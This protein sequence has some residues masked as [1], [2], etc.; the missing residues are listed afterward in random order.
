MN[1]KAKNINGLTVI[2]AEL[3]D[4][5]STTLEVLV[6]A[7]SIYEN[8]EINGLSHFLEH[9]FFK[10]GKKYK[11]PKIVAETVDAFGGE[12]NAF[13][14][15]EYAGYYVKCAP[16]YVPQALDV[17]ADMMLHAQFPKEEMEREKGVV[18]QEIMMYEDMPNR[19]V[20]DKR[21]E[22][23]Y[24]DNS[25]GRTTLWPVENIQSFTQEHL[26]KHKQD[27]YTK[28]NLVVIVAGALPNR[29]DLEAMIIDL[30]GSLP[31][32]KNIETPPLL[33]TPPTEHE[34]FYD[35]KTQQNHVVMGAKGFS[36]HDDARY[37]AKMLTVLLWWTMSSRL[38]QNIREKKW[39]CYY[40]TATHYDADQDGV[41]MMRAGMDKEKWEGWLQ[42][43]YDEIQKVA[44]GDI[45]QDELIKALGNMKGKTQMGIETSDQLASFVGYQQLF[46]AKI[47]SLE[48]ILADYEKVTLDQVKAVAEKL[49]KEKL[50]TYW[51]E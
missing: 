22:R 42:A 5:N 43:M 14:G 30:F 15:D 47:R 40:I 18:I 32:K 24:G 25:Y 4:A 11:T 29:S 26:F 41:F 44:D 21:Q 48:E 6:K 10:W 17:L 9:M 2:F 46:K 38:F 12:F 13:T 34:S 16:D 35:K 36:M 28:D 50:W 49:S 45:H 3:P 8:K 31:E 20:M 51:I 1:Y 39:L 23:Y 33:Y 27:L 19:L 37:A 7:G